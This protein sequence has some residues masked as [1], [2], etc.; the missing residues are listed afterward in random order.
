MDK[1]VVLCSEKTGIRTDIPIA[2]VAAFYTTIGNGRYRSI[3]GID[4][5]WIVSPE[6]AVGD[7]RRRPVTTVDCSAAF[8]K[9]I[10]NCIVD[11]GAVGNNRGGIPATSK[12]TAI[13]IGN[14]P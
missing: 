3:S 6:D 14:I 10:T 2:T 7:R 13:L 4:F 8:T 1:V 12:A 11:D 5:I 9:F